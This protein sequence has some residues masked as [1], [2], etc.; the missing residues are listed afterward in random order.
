MK[1]IVRWLGIVLLVAGYY[2]LTEDGSNLIRSNGN[3][4]V[5]SGKLGGYE[6]IRNVDDASFVMVSIGEHKEEFIDQWRYIFSD[7]M[8][9]LLIIIAVF[10]NIV[11]LRK[12]AKEEL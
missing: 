9:M 12:L 11:L 8:Y 10:L 4:N 3:V 5:E 7:P 2:W 6:E 1:V